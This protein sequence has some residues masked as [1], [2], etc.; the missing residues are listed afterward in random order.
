MQIKDTKRYP[1]I[2]VTAQANEHAEKIV[3][4]L[5]A[6][7]LSVSKTSIVSELIMLCPIETITKHTPSKRAVKKSHVR[8][9]D[10]EGY[11]LNK[12]RPAGV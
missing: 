5:Q 12:S 1:H 8:K 7:G 4:A 2:R 11:F 3:E 6:R 9:D 10:G